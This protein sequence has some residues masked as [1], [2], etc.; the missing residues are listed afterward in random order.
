MEKS[1]QE[2]YEEADRARY[3]LG[4]VHTAL[5][6]YKEVVA[7]YPR[8]PQA[9]YAQEQIQIIRKAWAKIEQ[10]ARKKEVAELEKQKVE[11]DR[12]VQEEKEKQL[13][14]RMRKSQQ[15]RARTSIESQAQEEIERA[16]QEKNVEL[17][18]A[19]LY[20]KFT[21]EIE[22]DDF[23][24]AVWSKALAIHYG[25]KDKAKYE[26]VKLKV[27][28]VKARLGLSGS[29]IP[30]RKNSP[31]VAVSSNKPTTRPDTA[32]KLDKNTKSNPIAMAECKP[33]SPS[34]P[35]KEANPDKNV[36][37][38]WDIPSVD[39]SRTPINQRHIYAAI[40]WLVFSLTVWIHTS[41]ANPY[42]QGIDFVF[43]AIGAAFGVLIIS[44]AVVG[45]VALLY[46]FIKKTRMPGIDLAIPITGAVLTIFTVYIV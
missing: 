23:D 25:D 16:E 8:S 9:G 18:D 33:H 20:D 24:R 22:S 31:K 7:T 19:H 36:V 35:R 3:N 12:L 15:E 27:D 26:Y 46:K 42:T 45:L 34:V 11:R 39:H 41:L 38:F 28:D 29:E 32:S 4:D 1:A 13:L 43:T 21:K 5:K 10:R 40:A 17:G 37:D 6:L 14:I 30:E 44:L 2:L